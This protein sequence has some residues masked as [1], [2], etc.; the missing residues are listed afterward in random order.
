MSVG[1]RSSAMYSLPSSQASAPSQRCCGGCISSPRFRLTALF[2][3]RCIKSLIWR[4]FS[5]LFSVFLLFG[6][7][8]RHLWVPESADQIFDI[9]SI[10][11]FAFFILDMMIRIMVEPNYFNFNVCVTNRTQFAENKESS[12][13]C[14]LGSFIFWCDL[15]STATLLYDISFIN[16]AQYQ[17]TELHIELD[18]NGSP[19]SLVAVHAHF[20][21]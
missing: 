18:A 11:A 6:S 19:V 20:G 15:I 3:K 7:Q 17:F 21:F 1:G 16:K 9:I 13:N 10:V 8:M 14:V 5:V 2:L 12:A 4:G